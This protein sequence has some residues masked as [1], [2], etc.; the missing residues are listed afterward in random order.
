MAITICNAE[1]THLCDNRSLSC[2]KKFTIQQ[3]G[4]RCHRANSVTNYLNENV[5][6]FIRK[7]SWSLN[8]CGLNLLDY[9]IWDIMRK[10]FYKNLKRH[11]DIEDLSAAMS[12][13]SDRLTKRFINNSIDQWQMRLEKVVEEGGGHIVHLIWQHQLM[14]PGTF[15]YWYIVHS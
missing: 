9:V 5:P 2:E 8:S 4:A 10:M 11:E 14:I 15:S 7:E 13:E 3:Y 12:Y 6:D 1:E